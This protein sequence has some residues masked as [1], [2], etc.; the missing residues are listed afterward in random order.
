MARFYS[1]KKFNERGLFEEM[2]IAWG[3]PS[4][5]APKI[6]GD[7]RYLL[8]FDSVVVRDGIVEG[9]GGLAPQRRCPNLGGGR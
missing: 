9:G 5:A 3:L 8:E 1:G 4:L 6:M 2:C 7:N